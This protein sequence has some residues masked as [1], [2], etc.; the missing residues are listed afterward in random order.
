QS[1]Y[2]LD[3][4][5]STSNIIPE[6]DYFLLSS[7]SDLR[8]YEVLSKCAS[9]SKKKVILIHFKERLLSLASLDPLF[10]FR[11]YKLKDLQEIYC[12]IK[13]PSSCLEDILKNT[14]LSGSKVAIDISCFTKPFFF[15][16]IKLLSER[17]NVQK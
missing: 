6:F 8:A 2:S 10:S 4:I 16:I 1:V 17:F 7:G 11:S 13:N 5:N 9:V 12:E 15:Y 14:I 3:R